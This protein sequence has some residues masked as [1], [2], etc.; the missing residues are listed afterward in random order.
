MTI[1]SQKHKIRAHGKERRLHGRDS[2][3]HIPDSGVDKSF[4]NCGTP[5]TSGT[6]ATVQWY[7]GLIMKMEGQKLKKNT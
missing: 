1:L 5:T 7:T 4:S 2:K 3:Q 6:P